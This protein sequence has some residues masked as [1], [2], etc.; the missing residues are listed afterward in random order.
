MV[1]IRYMEEAEGE[2]GTGTLTHCTKRN[3]TDDRC[4]PRRDAV[5][6][7][8]DSPRSERVSSQH[9]TPTDGQNVIMY[10]DE[11]GSM[12]Q[13]ASSFS[14]EKAM[15]GGSL[16]LIKNNIKYKERLDVV[17]LSV[18]RTI[19]L[20]CIELEQIV[21]LSVYR[22][23]KSSYDVLEKGLMME[24]EGSDDGARR[25]HRNSIMKQ[26]ILAVFG[27]VEIVL[28]CTLTI[29]DFQGLMMQLEE[30][31]RPAAFGEAFTAFQL[32]ALPKN[33]LVRRTFLLNFCPTLPARTGGRVSAMHFLP[34][35]RRKK[36][37]K[38]IKVASLP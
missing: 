22:P 1:G 20:A 29:N 4:S 9:A 12:H 18:G 15:H 24:T 25:K 17:R 6:L 26:R 11:F 36:E 7:R 37:K 21:V 13:V 10:S 2:W 38:N 34:P 14:R 5:R 31:C 33:H 28:R 35:P 3:K 23:P 16:T 30:L 8:R 19:E 27:L 32:S